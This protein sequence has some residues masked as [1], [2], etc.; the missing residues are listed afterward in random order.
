MTE[1]IPTAPAERE[2]S[3][4]KRPKK[5]IRIEA[6]SLVLILGVPGSG[7]STFAVNH[8]PLDS[9]VSTDALRREIS[10]NPSNQLISNKAFLLAA[11]L[12]EER[13]KR[14]AL[15]VVDAQNLTEVTR[16][17]FVDKAKAQGVAVHVIAINVDV[18]TAVERDKAR[19]RPA[20][21]EYI[22]ERFRYSQHALR[23]MQKYHDGQ[24]DVLDG[25]EAD[26]V[27]VN[28]PHHEREAWEAD[29]VMALDAQHAQYLLTLAETGFVRRETEPAER[30]HD[31]PAGGVLFAPD[32]QAARELLE[33]S[34][35]PHQV[36]DAV[37]IA[38]RLRA[39]IEDEA[40]RDVMAYIL[41][42]RLHLNLTT[43]VALPKEYPWREALLETIRKEAADRHIEIPSL[44]LPE[45]LQDIDR[46]NVVREAP[47]DAPL[48]LVGDIQGCYR[49]MREL[50]GRVRRENLANKELRDPA[51]ERT[52]VFVGDMSDRGPF[53]AEAAIYICALV[54]SG[55]AI[56]IKGNHDEHLLKALKGEAVH[57]SET[58][59]TFR[60]LTQRLKPESIEKIIEVL[61]N[62]PTYKEWK[63]LVAVHGSLPRVPRSGEPLGSDY[64]KM[65][66]GI[67]T[68]RMRGGRQETHPLANTVAH[69][70]E[71]LIV[72]GHT[73][74]GPPSIH[75][76]SGSVNLDASVELKGR[77]YGLYYPEL[78]FTSAEEPDVIALNEILKSGELPT[79]ERLLL[80]IDYAQQ[81]GL[82][83]T[84]AGE[85]D[86]AGLTIA[87]YSP[88]TEMSR[89]WEAYPTLRHFRGLMVDAQGTIMARPF[90]KTHKA[91][92][93]IPLE[94]LE[95]APDRVFEKANGT[96][97]VL[98]HHHDRWRTSTKF[99]F[100]NDAYTKAADLMLADKNLESLNPA[101][102]Y[103]FEILLPHDAHIVDYEGEQ[104]LVLLNAIENAT[105]KP[106]AWEEVKATAQELELRTAREMT[107]Q[108]AGMTIAEIY[109]LAQTAGT[110]KNIEGLMAVY[111]TQSE[112]ITVKVK[113]REYDDKKFI[114]DRLDWEDILTRLDRTTLTMDERSKDELLL[115]QYDNPFVVSAL[116]TRLEWIHSRGLEIA[117]QVQELLSSPLQQAQEIYAQALGAGQDHASA[118][119]AAMRETY[120]VIMVVVKDRDEFEAG[121]KNAFMGFLRKMIASKE[122]PEEALRTY[123]LSR[124]RE[125]IAEETKTRGEAA[126]WLVP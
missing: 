54:R 95:I 47:D 27:T 123:A 62:A 81:Q 87:S 16:K 85:G 67:G 56:L 120:K 114:R 13:L 29:R 73:H 10:N 31:I 21:E 82:I 5:E 51:P 103:L 83:K 117:A 19:T 35:L 33:R 42:Q 80:F 99:S 109:R 106:D 84:K 89:L 71:Q 59:K 55:R 69:D 46:L 28:L 15:T 79:G 72:G 22:K 100:E 93:E 57:S 26:R 66:F 101:K 113:A 11:R 70:P 20:G 96:L 94:E 53:D 17:A 7:K 44:D 50:A 124:I 78:A 49:A 102:T 74:E 68:G 63:G 76:V 25:E 104:S 105:G 112:T 119:R 48:L 121:T 118:L 9:I 36:I 88:V 92:V 12:V 41:R 111:R 107:D 24:V 125:Q 116:E 97:I 23:L 126:Y 122:H 14:G 108:F 52:I 45:N 39:A 3:P 90:K 98:Y 38:K 18:E 58:Q 6:G 86:Y 77:L 30:L 61:E 37:A 43:A 2:P 4:E 40:V 32:T 110:L 1:R 75:T 91:G 8:F 65:L 64:T 115:Y 60:L 34:L